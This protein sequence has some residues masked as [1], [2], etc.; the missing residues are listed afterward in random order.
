MRLSLAALASLPVLVASLASTDS[1]RDADLPQ[2]GYLPNH[3]LDPNVAGS[4]SFKNLWTFM[5]PVA[6]EQWLAK[7]LVYTPNGQSELVITASEMNIVRVFDSK[8]GNVLNTRTLQPPFSAADSNCGDIPDWIGVTGTPIIDPNTDI[9]Y[10]FSKGYKDGTTSGTANGVY[11]MYAIRI[12]SLEDVAGFPVLI[13]GMNAD[14]DPARY[15][16]GGVAL[17]RPSLTELNGHIVAA[18]GSHCG[19][20]NYTGYLISV[21]KTPG[22]GPVSMWATEAAPGAPNPQPLDLATETGGKAGI[23]QSGMGLPTIGNNIFFVTGNGQGHANGN[24]PASGRLPMSTLDECIVRMELSAAGKLSLIDYFQPY[25]YIGLD[26][27]DRDVGSSGLAVLDPSV[28]KGA[29]VN[30]IGVTAGKKGRTY[31]VNADNLGGFRQAPDGGDG[32]LQTIELGNSVYGGFGSYPAEG[33]Y[34]YASSIGGSL[35]AYKL[36]FDSKGAPQFSLAGKSAW[37]SAGR[38]GV[39]QIT[40]TSDNG[41]LGTG[42]VW[43]TDVNTGLMA[44]RAVPQDGVMVPLTLP[45]SQGTNKYQRPVFGDGRVFFHANNNKLVCFGAPVNSAVNCTSPVEFGSLEMGSTASAKVSCKAN[46]ALTKVNG[47]SVSD[48]SWTC[49][50]STLPQ[51]AVAAG[52]SFSLDV[53]WDLSNPAAKVVPGFFT[54]A[55]TLSISASADYASTT[56]VSLQGTAV[57]QGPF[58]SATPSDITFGRLVL[59]DAPDG[60]TATALLQNAGNGTLTFTGFAWQND[61]GTY[62]NITGDGG[63]GSGFS[64]SNFPAAGSSLGS[65]QSLSV[66]LR[67]FQ[68]ASG[69]YTTKIA[70]WSN[71]G[72]AVLTLSGSVNDPPAV[73]FELAD[74]LG[75]WNALSDYKVTFGNVLAGALVD[76]QIRVCNKGGAPLTI[77]ISKPPASPQL[78]ALNPNHELTE[79]T[80]VPPGTCSVGSVGVHA[81]PVQPNH[82]SQP[83]SALWTISTDGNDPVSGQASG[84]H[85]ILFEGTVVTKQVGPLLTNGTARYQ[86]VGCFKD[87]TN[88]GRNLANSVNNAAQQRTN[89]LQQCQGLCLDRG[90]ILSGVQYHQECWCGGNIKNPS[91]YT[92]ESLNLCTFDCTGDDTQAC[93]GDNGHMSLYADITSFDIQG[94]YGSLNAP[95]SSSSVRVATTSSTMAASSSRV[96]P[97]TSSSAFSSASSSTASYSSVAS[98]VLSSATSTSL[99]SS[100]SVFSSSGFAS[101]SVLSSSGG[102]GGD[103]G[104]I[105]TTSTIASYTSTSTTASSSPTSTMVMSPLNPRM[106]E[107]VNGQWRYA[108]CYKDLVNSTRLL[109]EAFLAADDMSLDKCA[110]F[111][112]AGAFNGGAF[113][114]FGVEYSR[115][116]YCGWD[117][118]AAET[119]TSEQECSA[120]CAGSPVGLCGA[121]YRLSVYRNTVPNQIP[122]APQHV[123]QANDYKFLGC[124][125]EGVNGRA[126]TGKFTAADTMAVEDCASFCSIDGWKL[127]GVEYGRECFCGNSTNAGSVPAPLAECNMLCMGNKFQYCGAGSRLDLYQLS[128]LASSAS[129]S[130]VVFTSSAVSSSPSILSSSIPA[131]DG[132]VLSTASST[133]RVPTVP[134]STTASSLSGTAPS[135]T[136]GPVATATNG[137][138]YVG[139]FQDTNTGHALPGLFAN[140]SVTPELC[141]DYANSKF[142]NSP[143]STTKMP[144]V[145]L[146][147]YHECYGGATFDFKGAAVTSLVGNKACKNYCYGSVSTFTTSGKVTTTTGTANYCGGARMFDL[148]ALSTPVAFPTTGGPLVTRT[149][150]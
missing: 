15:F 29:G 86:W 59:R 93:G 17:Q 64:S 107:V 85:N 88:L 48:P 51:G 69:S 99:S 13:D 33:G 54:S 77:T 47:C 141:I 125:S 46:V 136:I 62:T 126:L 38:V 149:V 139:C 150:N 129:S 39:G 32:V 28:F 3:N 112:G 84:L 41:R 110:A 5:S 133:G 123:P 128:P 132:A 80:Q 130:I 82:P 25:D 106:P 66:P 135:T 114:Y 27:G 98:S 23:W 1:Y 36:G 57:K 75:N 121:G 63:L 8:T 67:F 108:G 10:L 91:T 34:I 37:V 102:G 95:S 119:K 89:T 60:L 7:P 118:K 16:V 6:R 146:E 40:V 94:F 30:R 58:L 101:S 11:K 44:F 81:A 124:Q 144:Y 116:C 90:F 61:A 127:M 50:N 14:N 138:Y 142:S 68:Q 43:V 122:S 20:W 143:T 111:C 56:V 97:A 42:I 21:S 53:T 4:S 104:S 140:N 87:T 113:N 35:V 120:S 55:L 73:T 134:A 24:V 52:T 100:S 105:T 2:S 148:Y 109:N 49:S 78:F 115:E 65:G 71:G 103:G 74:G 96:I 145:F 117:V 92:Q 70:I 12:P 83:V 137:Y 79:G 18:F 76:K 72:T 147:Y 31:V 19:R 26:A 22:V 131:S 45:S 9:M